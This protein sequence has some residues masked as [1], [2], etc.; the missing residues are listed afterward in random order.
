VIRARRRDALRAHLQ[1]REIGSQIHYPLPIYRQA[2]YVDLHVN[3]ADYPEA[4]RAAREIL[5][6]PIYPEL[7]DAQVGAVVDALNSFPLL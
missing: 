6:L 3:P 7:T 1:A 2:A 4:E 5:S